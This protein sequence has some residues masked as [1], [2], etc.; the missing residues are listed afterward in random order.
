MPIEFPYDI[1]EDKDEERTNSA[2]PST[3]ETHLAEYEISTKHPVFDAAA[4][5]SGADSATTRPTAFTSAVRESERYPRARLLSLNRN[6]AAD[7]L[8]QLD[9]GSDTPGDATRQQLV[10]VLAGRT[11]LAREP[12]PTA[13]E[14]EVAKN[15]FAPW[16]LCYAGHQF[17]SFAGQLGDG[18]AISISAS[19]LQGISARGCL[20]P[21][22]TPSLQCRRLLPRKSAPRRVIGRSSCS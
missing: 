18:R 9:L 3:I 4:T 10:D 14:D 8:P 16:S 7:W 15:G 2:R 13:Q 11:V 17:G 22:L 1:R 6:F 12:D 5:A 20:E 21:V 19:P